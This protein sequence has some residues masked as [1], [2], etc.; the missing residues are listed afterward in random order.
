[1]GGQTLHVRGL[2]D[3]G[4]QLYDP[5][6]KTPVMIIYID[7]LEPIFGAAET[8]II[9]NTDPLEAIEQLDDSFRF[10]DKMRLIP[11]RGR[12]KKI[13]FYYALNRIT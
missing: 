11:Y 13:N 7:K 5:L 9:R 12:A 1:M 2:I 3:S 8:M 10:L 4:N 6:T